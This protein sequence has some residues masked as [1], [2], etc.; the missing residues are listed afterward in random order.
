MLSRWMSTVFFAKWDCFFCNSTS[1]RSHNSVE[2]AIHFVKIAEN[3]GS[4]LSGRR[5]ALLSNFAGHRLRPSSSFRCLLS[6]GSR[7]SSIANTSLLI[8]AILPFVVAV[9]GER[10]RDASRTDMRP[11]WNT[12]NQNLT[13]ATEEEALLIQHPSALCL[14]CPVFVSKTRI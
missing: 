8:S 14:H 7:T 11:H 13:F 4:H 2:I 10:F 5:S 1:S 9:S 12:I 6:L 3:N